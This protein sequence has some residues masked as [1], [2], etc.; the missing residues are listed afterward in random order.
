MLATLRLTL[1]SATII[2]ISIEQASIARA[3]DLTVSRVTGEISLVNSLDVAAPIVGYSINSPSGALLQGNWLS[4]ANHYDAGNGGPID[5]NDEWIIIQKSP[6]FLVEG[7]ALGDGGALAPG[8]VLS[9][10]LA[11]DP[12]LAQDLV[13]SIADA[14]GST[15]V[16]P[17]YTTFAADFDV[18]LRVDRNDLALWRICF[19]GGCSIGDADD[20]G[21]VNGQ[22]YFRWLEQ[23]GSVGP[24]AP[25]RGV[26]GD[27][28]D[29]SMVT[30]ADYALWRDQLG[31]MAL[32]P[33]DDTPGTVDPS[34]YDDWVANFGGMAMSGDGA[35]AMAI[36][37][38]SPALLGSAGLLALAVFRRRSRC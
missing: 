14:L 31:G 38:P 13:V 32:L 30:A 20:S 5:P 12:F 22:D 11:W 21:T 26:V 27:F 23:A 35:A 10:G 16:T 9:L 24:I 6:N 4:I 7:E 34:D 33:N 2:L 28:N 15:T 3:I 18:N 29:D 17:I 37:E 8:Q 36:P 1:V 19:V 25:P